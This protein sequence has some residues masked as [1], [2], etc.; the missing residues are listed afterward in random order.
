MMITEYLNATIF[1]MK[2]NGV[3]LYRKNTTSNVTSISLSRVSRDI[4]E[5][6][7]TARVGALTTLKLGI[8]KMNPVKADYVRFHGFAS[9]RRTFCL[10][11]VARA[12]IC[13]RNQRY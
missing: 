5:I 12:A 9:S 1:L 6:G 11:A 4:R 10:P 2:K 13:F 8:T 3:K 7:R